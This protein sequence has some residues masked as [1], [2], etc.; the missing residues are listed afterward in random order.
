M[1]YFVDGTSHDNVFSALDAVNDGGIY[2]GGSS[3]TAEDLGMGSG[4]GGLN[5]FAPPTYAED[6]Y[7]AG[8]VTSQANNFPTSGYYNTP[9]QEHNP[10]LSLWDSINADSNSWA[11]GEGW[12][13]D[14]FGISSGGSGG[15]VYGGQGGG[16]PA[17]VQNNQ[18][19]KPTLITRKPSDYTYNPIT[20]G[21]PNYVAP[22]PTPYSYNDYLYGRG[23]SNAGADYGSWGTPYNYGVPQSTSSSAV[24]GPADN[25]INQPAINVSGGMGAVSG[26]IADA[27]FDDFAPESAL[28]EYPVEST[29]RFIQSLVQGQGDDGWAGE[30]MLTPAQ[31]EYQRKY[32]TYMDNNPDAGMFDFDKE[33]GILSGDKWGEWWDNSGIKDNLNLLDFTPMATLNKVKQGIE[34]LLNYTPPPPPPDWYPDI[35]PVTKLP[36]KPTE[37]ETSWTQPET[38]LTFHNKDYNWNNKSPGQVE[39]LVPEYAPPAP[40]V[41]GKP[42]WVNP[43]D[44][45]DEYI[46]EDD[47]GWVSYPHEIT[48][49]GAHVPIGKVSSARPDGQ[50]GYGGTI[51]V[52]TETN[53]LDVL[54][55]R[56]GAAEAA[57]AIQEIF[58]SQPADGGIFNFGDT[59]EQG[60]DF[61]NNNYWYI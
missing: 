48:N 37:G 10:T 4:L 11:G 18:S 15:N 51:P 57:I 58:D 46:A 3:P 17:I 38:G 22:T 2:G 24:S 34:N 47:S 41:E 28:R 52:G 54:G 20:V 53:M 8:N 61:G 30:G 14:E 43:G 25:A 49:Q 26:G 60:A 56:P 33:H 19:S 1:G 23:L 55:D 59:V 9:A 32:R 12:D 42:A 44:Y 40:I 35:H 45:A 31:R 29:N 39:P 16:G 36:T 27:G 6:P 7:Y 21:N 13:S 50:Y 5:D